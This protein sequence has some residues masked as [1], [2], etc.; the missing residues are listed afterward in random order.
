MGALQAMSW[1]CTHWQ[2]WPA[3]MMP[4][5]QARQSTSATPT[6]RSLDTPC[7]CANTFPIIFFVTLI[8]IPVHCCS[9]DQQPCPLLTQLGTPP[10]AAHSSGGCSAR[11]WATPSPCCPLTSTLWCPA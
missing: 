7:P 4:E 3:Y 6:R 2:Q 10:A 5:G 8:S 11:S 9:T 1:A